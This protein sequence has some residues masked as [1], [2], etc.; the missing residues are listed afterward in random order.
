MG[1]P[2]AALSGRSHPFGT[3]TRGC[4]ANPLVVIIVAMS[5]GPSE[6]ILT[7]EDLPSMF[8]SADRT[9]L[10]GQADTVRWSA[11]Q[12]T[13]LIAGSVLG[14]FDIQL[15]NGL[16]V[17]ALVAA[18]ALAASLIPALW[19]TASN[20]QRVWYRGRAA[21]ESLRTLAWKYAVRA[22]PFTGTDASAD[23]R[24]L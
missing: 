10:S 12:L 13:L 23:E 20:P 24:L 19:L 4:A 15:D 8:R 9:S 3:G 17:G 21:A 2:R 22:E 7:D 6:L 14:G 1:V 18:V 5:T 16:D 11:L